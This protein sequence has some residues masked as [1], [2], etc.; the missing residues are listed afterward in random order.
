MPRTWWLR[1]GRYLLYVLRDLSPLPPIIWLLLFLSDVRRLN[2]GPAAFHPETPPWFIAFSVSAS[3][4]SC[5]T[6]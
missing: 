5:Y 1:Q 2:D 4:V 3:P 6:P